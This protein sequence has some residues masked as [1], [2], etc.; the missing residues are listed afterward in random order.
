MKIGI[1]SDIHEDITSLKKAFEILFTQ[2]CQKIICL[3][4]VVGT[5][6]YRNDFEDTKNANACLSMLKKHCETILLGNHDNFH[7][8]KLPEGNQFFDFPSTWYELSQQEQENLANKNLWLYH[9]DYL[10]NLNQKDI[11]YLNS[12][13]NHKIEAPILYSHYVLP[14]LS[15]DS[16]VYYKKYNEIQKHFDWMKS[17]NCTLGFV[18]H[19]HPKTAKQITEDGHF[20]EIPWETTIEIQTSSVIVCPAICEKK[21][22]KQGLLIFDSKENTLIAKKL[23]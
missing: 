3:G 15:G 11:E 20:V 8:Q 6:F 13:S 21:G 7:I 17:E 12:C 19:E 22:D 9:T 4:D 23:I 16:P 5:A 2:N 18:G 14:D 1:I 10:T